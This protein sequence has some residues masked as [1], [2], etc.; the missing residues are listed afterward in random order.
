MGISIFPIHNVYVNF[1]SQYIIEKFRYCV[2][3]TIKMKLSENMMKLSSKAIG[4]YIF[5]IS[6]LDQFSSLYVNDI[7]FSYINDT[8]HYGRAYRDFFLTSD[9]NVDKQSSVASSSGY[10][11][12]YHRFGWLL[13]LALRV[14]VFSR[15]K[16]LVTCTN[17][18]VSVL[19][20]YIP[21]LHNFID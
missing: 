10:V 2:S 16:D 5:S 13:F 3:L 9:A 18:L 19:V 4:D 14:H 21:A 1:V 20:S 12:D 17:G 6:S 11:S 15:C 7:I 8:R